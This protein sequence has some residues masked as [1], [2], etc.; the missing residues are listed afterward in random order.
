MSSFGFA[1]GTIGI[2]LLVLLGWRLLNRIFLV[3][4]QNLNRETAHEYFNHI[5]EVQ[6]LTPI[7]STLLL[8]PGEVAFYEDA[9]ELCEKR[10]SRSLMKP[11]KVKPRLKVLQAGVLVLT[12]QRL[13]F[14]GGLQIRSLLLNDIVS[15]KAWVDSVEL[16]LRKSPISKFYR[17]KNP[18]IWSRLIEG[19]TSG[20]LR[21]F[22]PHNPAK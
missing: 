21:E 16:T 15:A 17:V 6:K 2:V 11:A 9:A 5:Q 13:V 10:R 19:I 12:D 4:R 3:R 22:I 8:M 7:K 1:V 18:L 20:S 14:A